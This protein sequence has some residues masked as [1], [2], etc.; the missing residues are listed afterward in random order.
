MITRD[1]EIERKARDMISKHGPRAARVAAER[2]NEMIDRGNIRGR[3]IWAC[4]VHLIHER[5]GSGPVWAEGPMHRH[6]VG[7][8]VG[9][10][11]PLQ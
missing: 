5:Q 7:V 2:L 9:M 6:H 10:R 8:G 4:I 11:V 1:A 3:D